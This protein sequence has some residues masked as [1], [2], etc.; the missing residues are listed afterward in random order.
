MVIVPH[1]SCISTIIIV[2]HCMKGYY[3]ICY[4]CSCEVINTV[5]CSCS[6]ICI[7][8]IYT[9]SIENGLMHI[10]KTDQ[11]IA[12]KLK[13]SFLQHPYNILAEC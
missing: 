1:E 7:S 5:V 10:S 12:I 13:I 6:E 11:A 4:S 9:I 2:D 3:T 8:E